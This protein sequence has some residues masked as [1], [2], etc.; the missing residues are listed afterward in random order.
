WFTEHKSEYD[1]II[2]ENKEFFNQIYSELQNHDNITGMHISRI[3]RDIRFSKD[4]TPFKPNFG[5]GYSRAKP[6]L[7][8]GYYLQVE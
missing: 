3:Y 8:G 4:K 5:V 2:K 6:M 1:L 7:R